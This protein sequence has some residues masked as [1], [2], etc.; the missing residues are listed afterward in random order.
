[1]LP[2]LGALT[3]EAIESGLVANII[4]YGLLTLGFS[5][6]S[7]QL[8][9][10]GKEEEK[11]DVFKSK[12]KTDI[13]ESST[14][15]GAV[16]GSISKSSTSVSSTSG[17]SASGSSSVSSVPSPS[18]ISSSSEATEG[19]SEDYGGY[20][21][22]PLPSVKGNSLIEVLESSGEATSS[23]IRAVASSVEALRGELR[24]IRASIEGLK[25]SPES[26]TQDATSEEL[27][28]V[29]K[30]IGAVLGGIG[31]GLEAIRLQLATGVNVDLPK[32]VKESSIATKRVMDKLMERTAVNPE[33]FITE[34]TPIDFLTH[35]AGVQAKTFADVNS[36][37]LDNDLPD[38]P[39]D[40]DISKIFEFLR[41]S[42][43]IQ[44]NQT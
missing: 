39:Q 4:R 43:Q 10:A 15:A 28:R 1:M 27:I 6:V 34:G 25:S 5:L 30:G 32:E 8:K 38:F 20:A 33:Q 29:L 41:V 19:E 37:D 11:K 3:F 9:E 22:N 7:H 42:Q 23:S 35:S 17:S 40:V 44:N 26:K 24:G 12:P 2:L 36:F 16:S 31:L 21:G 14:P 18:S 13:F